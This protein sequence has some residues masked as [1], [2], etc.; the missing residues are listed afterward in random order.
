MVLAMLVAWCIT[1]QVCPTVPGIAVFLLFGAGTHLAPAPKLPF[2]GKRMLAV[3][4]CMHQ[5]CPAV[6]LRQAKLDS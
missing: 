2:Q 6:G 5:P 1:R 3:G 4:H